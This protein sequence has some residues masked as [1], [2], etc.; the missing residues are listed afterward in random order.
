VGSDREQDVGR[1]VTEVASAAAAAGTAEALGATLGRYRLE[2]ELGAGGMGVVHAAFDPVLERRIALK[3]LNRAAA[4]LEARERLLREAR[5]M[6]R[7]AHPNVVTVYEVD[8]ASGR[9]FVAMEM[10]HG[11]TL[12]TW[13]RAEPRTSAAILDAFLAAGRGLAA[14][15]AAGIVHRDF[16]PHNVLRSRAGRIA[17]T[18]FGLAREVEGALPAGLE[19]TLPGGTKSS[20]PTALAGLTITGSLVGTPAYMAP[21]QWQGAAVTAATDQFAYCV[22]LWEALAGERP[23]RGPTFDELRSQVARGPAALDASRIPRRVR[24]LLRRG[25]DPDPARRWPGM[26]ALLARLVRAQRRPGVALAIAGG[27]LVAAVALGL[28]LRPGAPPSVCEPPARDLAT[29]WSPAIAAEL[30]AKTSEAHTRVLSAAFRDWQGA[31]AAACGAPPQVRQA[32][33]AC[34][35][36]VLARFDVL[37]QAYLRVPDGLAEDLQANLVDPAVCQKRAAAEIPR[38][39]LAPTPSTIAA[40]AL[41]VRSQTEHKP[42]EAEIAAVAGAGTTDPCARVIAGLAFD[43]VSQG[44]VRAR[45]I[46]AEAESAAD[47][48]G[49][50][51]LRADLMI[52]D[53]PY[54]WELPMAGPKADAAIQRARIAATR[55][56][57]PELEAALAALRRRVTRR[58][59]QWDEAFRM[60]EIELA[61]YGTHD[62]EVRK[63]RAMLGRNALRLG[64]AEPSDL[65][66]I[67]GDVQT[68][69]PIAVSHHRLDLARQLEVQDAK[70]R[71]QFGDVASAHADLVRLWLAEPRDT[72]TVAPHTITGEV[73]DATGRPVAGATVAAAGALY[74]DAAGV[75]LPRFYDYLEDNLAIVTS[76]GAGQFAIEHAAQVGAIAA[77]LAD[78]RSRPVA[79]ADRV[80]LVLEPTRR[81]TG[82]VNLGRTS[83]TRIDVYAVAVGDPSGAYS[84]VA[85]VGAD[86]SFAM[87][88]V[89]MGAFRIGALVRDD[90][91]LDGQIDYRDFPAS[92]TPVTEVT[93][94]LTSSKR[95]LDVIVHSA[96]AAPLDG[97]LVILLP[98]KHEVARMD[99]LRQLA[100][101]GSLSHFARPIARDGVPRAVLDRFHPGDLLTHIEHAGAGELTVCGFSFVGDW[102][103]P[104]FRQRAMA[105]LSELSFKCTQ[106]GPDTAVVELLVPPQQRFD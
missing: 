34:L 53:N 13:L 32:Q 51:R 25:L 14:A 77:Q 76:D 22:A 48:C 2:R 42:S 44:V 27:A 78:R 35:D 24:G 33:L 106:I 21:E 57:Q 88:G 45:S 38:L 74:A 68:W 98:G 86:G 15:H 102:M 29:V 18:D 20:A 87:A 8:T 28:A 91:E 19:T 84:L 1:T 50:E 56:M 95:V 75:G 73:V 7:L 93:L 30:D 54:H 49:D 96:V 80:K 16:K 79:I 11:E 89:P 92:P 65:A 97:A 17:V 47:Q 39:M 41:L 36:G 52:Q 104:E 6:A 72:K 105:H 62:L 103:D 59:G 37:R 81:V 100:T 85:P 5:A 90:T 67:A 46:L 4:T 83:H 69:R 40:F 61:G 43:A 31:R 101:R 70:A 3:V 71:F 63:L 94:E 9:D 55:V 60:S 99:D 26:N 58:R 23:Y 66:A 82:K 10:I 64:R 12:A